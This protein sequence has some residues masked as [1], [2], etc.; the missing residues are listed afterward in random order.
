MYSIYFR[1]KA[2]CLKLQGEYNEMYS[3][4]TSILNSFYDCINVYNEI[5]KH[6]L[7]ADD[8]RS[9]E[10]TYDKIATFA[11]REYQQVCCETSISICKILTSIFALDN[12]SYQFRPVPKEAVKH[13]ILQGNGKG[14]ERAKEKNRR[15]KE[16][17]NHPRKTNQDR[18]ERNKHY[19]ERQ[20]VCLGTSVE[21]KF[22][23]C[24][25][26]LFVK[27]RIFQILH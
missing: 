27:L 12:E 19:V 13:Q 7:T 6:N 20:R 5:P 25:N 10:D 9:M 17:P 4:R 8:Y 18:R 11:D 1:L 15:R 21:V 26:T 24:N 2:G 14:D 16:G 22:T 23:Y 3:D